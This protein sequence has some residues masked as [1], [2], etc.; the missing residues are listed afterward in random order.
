[1]GTYYTENNCSSHVYPYITRKFKFEEVDDPKKGDIILIKWK[2]HYYSHVGIFVDE[3]SF[4]HG[5]QS[6]PTHISRYQ[7]YSKY[8]HKIVRLV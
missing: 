8:E 1:M 3:F 5:G 7:L 2:R 6:V 4:R